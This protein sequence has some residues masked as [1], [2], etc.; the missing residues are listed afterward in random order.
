M[1]KRGLNLYELVFGAFLVLKFANVTPIATW[2]W[3]FIL[4]PII[5]GFIHKFFIWVYEG[6]QMKREIDDLM[7]DTYVEIRKRQIAKKH[8]RNVLKQNK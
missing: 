5:I 1:T 7:A 2:N 4:L 6:T 3:F 8:I